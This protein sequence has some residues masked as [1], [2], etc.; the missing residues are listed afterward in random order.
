VQNENLV[1]SIND[2]S[3]RTTL[4][5]LRARVL[6]RNEIIRALGAKYQDQQSQNAINE[7]SNKL[8]EV[9]KAR[10]LNF[11]QIVQQDIASQD[12]S[13]REEANG[14]P[15]SPTAAQANTSATKPPLT[16]NH[17][18]KKIHEAN[19][20]GYEAPIITSLIGSA[21]IG[22]SVY[23]FINVKSMNIFLGV[24]TAIGACLLAYAI[25]KTTDV[26]KTKTIYDELNK[27]ADAIGL[28]L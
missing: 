7:S 1:K 2:Y 25:Y 28:T 17:L 22:F 20:L 10:V 23:G 21:T 9:Y 8:V 5:K 12:Y 18:G 27:A 11:T 19:E 24:T 3:T 6:T 16:F 15:S 13:P 14:E 4:D 26:Y